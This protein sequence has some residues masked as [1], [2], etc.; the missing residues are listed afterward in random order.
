M[1]EVVF[2]RLQPRAVRERTN[3]SCAGHRAW[4]RRHRCSVRG[5]SRTPIECAHVRRGADGGAGMKP[6][7]KW[8]VSL[9]IYH[10]REQHQ[11][12]ERAFEEKYSLDL[13]TL[14]GEFA[15][16]SPL[17]HKLLP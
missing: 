7:D 2:P 8:A 17:S 11:I 12:G 6:S 13:V 4:V 5:C 14:A 10:H 16:R 3:R 1:P 15:R 9:C